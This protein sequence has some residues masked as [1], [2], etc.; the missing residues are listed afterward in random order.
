MSNPVSPIPSLQP[1]GPA[2]LPVWTRFLPPGQVVLRE[3]DSGSSMFVILEGKV[4]VCREP[5]QRRDARTLAMLSAGD[6]FG[7]LALMTHCPRMASVV[8]MERTV[9][10]EL[11]LNGL[12]VA[13]PRH[14]VEAPVVAM[15]CRERLLGDALR[16]SPLL[17]GLS[18]GLWAQLGGALEP[19]SVGVGE[20]LLTRGHPG[21]ALYVLLRGRCGVFHTHGDGRITAYPDMVEGDLFGEVSLLR[22]R[23][24]T[25]TVR[26]RT[27]CT[28]LRLDQSVFR[29]LFWGQAE[30][31][32]ALVSLGL[33]RMHRTMDVIASAGD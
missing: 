24:A 17:S 29:K 32:R 14:G 11:S 5:T 8:T 28:L 27:P 19:C 16:C 23:L 31:R 7:E 20:T 21:D 4:A 6:F 9:V 2:P 12:A 18:P 25:A 3:G 10:R 1:M 33:E 13:G 15:R 26:A 22:G 30:I